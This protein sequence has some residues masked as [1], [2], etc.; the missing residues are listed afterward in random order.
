MYIVSFVD[1]SSVRSSIVIL[2]CPKI[3]FAAAASQGYHIH[4]T[5]TYFTNRCCNFLDA[6]WMYHIDGL[7]RAAT[8]LST[9]QHHICSLLS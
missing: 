3:H 6:C 7:Y 2:Y 4:C 8:S 9:K 5:H 1:S